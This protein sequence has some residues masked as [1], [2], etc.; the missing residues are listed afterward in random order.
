MHAASTAPPAYEMNRRLLW[1]R[2][3]V[4]DWLE[5]RVTDMSRPAKRRYMAERRNASAGSTRGARTVASARYTSNKKTT[6]AKR[7]PQKSGSG[8][9]PPGRGGKTT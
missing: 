2:S 6:I 9:V 4:V 7:V 3:E 1:K 5:S 8:R